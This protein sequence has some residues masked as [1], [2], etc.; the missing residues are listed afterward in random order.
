MPSFAPFQNTLSDPKR[1]P[2]QLRENATILF[3]QSMKR[4]AEIEGITKEIEGRDAIAA[5]LMQD[6]LDEARRLEGETN[7]ETASSADQNAAEDT[8]KTH[9][10]DDDDILRILRKHLENIRL[11]LMRTRQPVHPTQEQM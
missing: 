11:E 4:K 6:L 5:V 7:E 10:R 1:T 3:Y 8:E 9:N 2:T